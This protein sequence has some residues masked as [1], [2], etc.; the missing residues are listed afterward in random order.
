[1]LLGGGGE[2]V[3]VHVPA[4][5]HEVAVV[6]EAGDAELG[7][8]QAGAVVLAGLD[9]LDAGDCGG[10]HRP[11]E[12]DQRDADA[13]ALRRARTS[14]DVNLHVHPRPPFRRYVDRTK[15]ACPASRTTVNFTERRRPP[16]TADAP[17]TPGRKTDCGKVPTSA[18]HPKSSEGMLAVLLTVRT[19][20]YGF[21]AGPVPRRH[22]SVRSASPGHARRGARAVMVGEEGLEPSKA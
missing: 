1:M 12:A 20:M 8:G 6:G 21:T 9:H 7:Q 5:E 3:A 2:V 13:L 11:A 22:Q 18:E 14:T 10:G 19:T 17:S 4:G 15:S 16:K